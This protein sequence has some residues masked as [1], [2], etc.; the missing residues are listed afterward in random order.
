VLHDPALYLVLLLGLAQAPAPPFTI[1]LT[2]TAGKASKTAH[3]EEPREGFAPNRKPAARPVLE[4]RAGRPVTVRWKLTRG[5]GQ[6]AVKGV[7]VHFFATPEEK[8]GQAVKA[9]KDNPVETALTM[10]FKAGERAEGELT[11]TLERAGAYLLRLETIGAGDAD[12]R[13][14]A[15]AL[16][17]VLR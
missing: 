16:D 1:D 17:L 4:A 3:A 5:A 11:F 8:A 12:G 9:R 14:S 15:A 10:D 13:E 2:V 6:P 7:I